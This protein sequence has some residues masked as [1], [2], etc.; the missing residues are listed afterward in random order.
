MNGKATADFQS[1]YDRVAI[2]I[3]MSLCYA[4]QS[5]LNESNGLDLQDENG[6]GVGCCPL[7]LEVTLVL[8][9]CLLALSLAFNLGLTACVMYFLNMGY[10]QYNLVV[11]ALIAAL[12]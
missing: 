9:H 10:R 8:G 11:E 2:A 3:L 1:A 5:Y 7:K 4:F 12:D 6:R